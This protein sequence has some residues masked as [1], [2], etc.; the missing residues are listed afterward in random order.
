MKLKEYL[1]EN[2]IGVSQF[3][4]LTEITYSSIYAYINETT[5]PSRLIARRI[6]EMTKG[7]V[8]AAD[9]RKIVPVKKR[10]KNGDV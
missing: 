4:A 7:K 5:R 8:K 9:L 6:E 1:D 10:A 2:D 3:A